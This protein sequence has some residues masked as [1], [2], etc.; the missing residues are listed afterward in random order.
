MKSALE[1]AMG[2]TNKPIFN[3]PSKVIFENDDIRVT[4]D[5][6]RTTIHNLGD[7]K[8]YFTYTNTMISNKKAIVRVNIIED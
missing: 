7:T 6:S 8:I 2:K 1:I 5:E 3:K 4:E